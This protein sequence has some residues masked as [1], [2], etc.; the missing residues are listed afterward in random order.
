[1]GD[2][3]TVAGIRQGHSREV[4]TK[5][6]DPLRRSDDLSAAADVRRDVYV[7][8]PHGQLYLVL[9]DRCAVA[10]A[11]TGQ[12]RQGLDHDSARIPP[13]AGAA[14]QPVTAGGFMR[15]SAWN[16]PGAMLAGAALAGALAAAPGSAM[17][18]AGQAVGPVV[19]LEA[20]QRNVTLES[21]GGK[22]YLD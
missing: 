3:Q 19:T 17:A 21:F 11:H 5:L 2:R 10:A 20:A 4:G 8:R 1:A 6:L 15:R 12:H 9:G 16:R 13:L 18:A 14:R 22:V 7:R